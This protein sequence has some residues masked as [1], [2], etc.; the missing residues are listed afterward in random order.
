MNT[1]AELI[2]WLRDAYAMEKA[3]E[4]ILKKLT[5][6]PQTYPAL[7]QQAQ[8]HCLATREHSDVIA[9][10]LKSLGADPS[11]LKTVLAQGMDL[12]RH[13][14]TTFTRDER[15]KDVLTVLVAEHFEIACHTILRTGAAQ[16]GMSDIVQICDEILLEE[17]RMTKWLQINLPQIIASCLMPEPEP[18]TALEDDHDLA[19]DSKAE[20]ATHWEFIQLAQTA[21]LFGGP[22][23]GA[24][25]VLN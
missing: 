15:L 6:H 23:H 9:I 8:Q 18:V 20:R 24:T 19:K 1:K 25:L 17:K 13:V 14:G 21:T 10:C 5:D 2:D 16:A 11:S 3:M 12:M 7:R 22:T 4:V